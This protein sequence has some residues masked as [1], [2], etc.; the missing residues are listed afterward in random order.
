MGCF[1]TIEVVAK[2][3]IEKYLVKFVNKVIMPAMINDIKNKI[4]PELVA[5]L[6]MTEEKLD[7]SSNAIE[8]TL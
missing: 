1:K 5:Q 8:I 4:I 2:D 7:V 3:D 6:N